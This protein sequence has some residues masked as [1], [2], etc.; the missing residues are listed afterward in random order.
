[1]MNLSDVS[2]MV[3]GR[4]ISIANRISN[5]DKIQDLWDTAS[6]ANEIVVMDG[7]PVEIGGLS[8][9]YTSTN[10]HVKFTP[11]SVIHP[12]FISYL[13]ATINNGN[14]A[15]G[16]SIQDNIIL[17]N[18]QIDFDGYPQ[19]ITNV[20]QG[21]SS[22]TITLH[23]SSSSVNDYYKDMLVA[24]AAGTGF[25]SAALRITAYNGSTKVATVS[26]SWGTA[27]ANGSVYKLGGSDNAIAFG[28]GATNVKI[29]G[30]SAK[31]VPLGVISDGKA[32]CLDQGV[33]GVVIDRFLAENCWEGYFI[34]GKSG[35]WENGAS[36]KAVNVKLLNSHA[37]N[38]GAALVIA[39]IDGSGDPT[40]TSAF[41][42]VIVDNF[43]FTNC[44]H[45]T[46]RMVGTDQQK[47]GAIVFAEAEGVLLSNVR[48]YNSGAWTSSLVYPTDFTQRCGYGLS[49]PVGSVI[50]G[51]GRDITIRDVIVEGDFDSIIRINRGRAIGDD[52]SGRPVNVFDWDIS[53]LRHKGA[54]GTLLELDTNASARVTSANLRMRIEA[55]TH[56]LS[57]GIV[58]SEM[59]SYDGVLLTVNE[60]INSKKVE[61]LASEI[62]AGGNTF[63]S[64][65]SA[66]TKLSDVGPFS[67]PRRSSHK[68]TGTVNDDTCIQ[69]TPQCQSGF[70]EFW[71]GQPESAASGVH[72]RIYYNVTGTAAVCEL[73]TN[74]SKVAVGTGTLT[75][76]TGNGT[77]TKLN[78]FAHTDGKLY[79]KNRIGSARNWSYYFEDDGR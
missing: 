35:V 29:I 68:L 73:M 1:M 71:L 25:P 4:D 78:I 60:P 13:G 39:S 44:G 76:G 64:F 79:F 11:G 20:A 3:F 52:A 62:Y 30:G 51:W 14:E 26:P 59:A 10:L 32:I 45:A 77:D 56:V 38:C 50:W 28:G 54:A 16:F 6:A 27:P 40:G 53:G 69:L 19:L 66:H 67:L 7:G 70:F 42:N 61:G 8:S 37:V 43:S 74:S 24:I 36:K 49:G 31:N 48:G 12:C 57:T 41:E 5:R 63:V 22:T 23:N 47:S 55:A 2:G 17:E 58:G 15:F 21:G 65:P 9:L 18:P 75:T 33:D 34:Q 72:G 46:L